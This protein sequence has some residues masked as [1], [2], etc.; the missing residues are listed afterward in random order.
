MGG[1][2]QQVGADL[3]ELC[4]S[5]A[6]GVGEAA[7]SFVKPDQGKQLEQGKSDDKGQQALIKKQ[8][9]KRQYQEVK[10]QLAEYVQ[11]KKQQDNQVA[12]E[13]QQEEQQNVQKKRTEKQEKETFLQQ[14]MKNL[15]RGSHGETDRQ[16]E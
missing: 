5:V 9:E 13:K 11:R 1:I 3:M 16:K 8:K 4:K 14:L 6:K 12:Q 15:A 2:G 7:V 10:N